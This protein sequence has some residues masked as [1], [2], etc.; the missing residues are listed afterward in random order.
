MDAFARILLVGPI[1]Y[2][3]KVGGSFKETRRKV[4]HRRVSLDSG[5]NETGPYERKMFLRCHSSVSLRIDYLKD[6]G[7]YVPTFFIKIQEWVGVR[8]VGLL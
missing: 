8:H 4:N 1:L 2:L 3:V 5:Q 7:Y 6:R